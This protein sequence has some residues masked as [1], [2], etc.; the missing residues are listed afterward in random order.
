[1]TASG[2]P[3]NSGKRSE[4]PLST[5]LRKFGSKFSTM[6]VDPNRMRYRGKLAAREKRKAKPNW[7][8]P[9]EENS[10]R[11]TADPRTENE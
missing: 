9:D 6:G 5:P 1:M 10:S 4:W 7:R 2:A 11:K 3:A 8:M